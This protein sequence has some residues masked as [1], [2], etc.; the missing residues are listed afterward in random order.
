[1]WGGVGVWVCVCV[2]VRSGYIVGTDMFQLQSEDNL[3]K[4]TCWPVGGLGLGFKIQV[5][6]RLRGVV[7]PK[8]WR[9]HYGV[10]SKIRARGFNYI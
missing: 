9:R 4:R 3:A 2:F 5:R 10:L 8:G 6:I 1:V 7:R